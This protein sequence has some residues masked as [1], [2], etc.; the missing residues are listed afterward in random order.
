MEVL[1]VTPESMG[2]K[3]Q[4]TTSTPF[5]ASRLSGAE[6]STSKNWARNGAPETIGRRRSKP[7]ATHQRTKVIPRYTSS[8]RRRN[9]LSFITE[10][11]L[12]ILV[13]AVFVFIA[14]SVLHMVLPIHKGDH[15]KLPNETEVLDAMRAAGVKPASYM[16]PCPASMKDMAS[17][18][19]TA[20]YEQGPVGYLTVLPSGSPSIGKSLLQWFVFSI[21]VGAFVAY[22]ARLALAPGADSMLVFRITATVAT[23]GYAM[24]EVPNSIW[25][26]VSWTTTAKFLFDGLI[27]GVVTGAAFYWLWPSA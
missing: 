19:M 10:L 5:D 1:D 3:N 11:W 22:V 27:Y 8:H 18:E 4:K 25:K 24:A 16:F 15:T 7:K 20:K 6:K 2:Q 17:P 9:H 13:A 14:S 12:A 26:G 23:L 21:V